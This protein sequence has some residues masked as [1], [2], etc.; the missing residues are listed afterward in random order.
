M[1]QEAEEREARICSDSE[2]SPSA[3]CRGT[4]PL[5]APPALEAP[6]STGSPPGLPLQRAPTLPADPRTPPASACL[7]DTLPAPASSATGTA[8]SSL[9][10]LCSVGLSLQERSPEEL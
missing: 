10:L 3:S 1:Q 6:G 7:S 5:Q 4:P 8:A 2:A 9:L